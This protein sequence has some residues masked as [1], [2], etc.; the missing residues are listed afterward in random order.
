M[1]RALA[2]ALDAGAVR[3]QRL[4][5][6][7][8]AACLLARRG[9]RPCSRRSSSTRAC[10]RCA[11][12]S[13]SPTICLT[14]SQAIRIL[15]GETPQ[16][17]HTDD[18]FYRIARPRRGRQPELHL[19]ASTRSPRRTAPRRCVPGSHRW[20]DATVGAPARA[21]STSRRVPDRPPASHA[22]RRR[23]RRGSAATS[24]TSSCR[25]A[26]ASRSSGRSCIAGARTA[27]RGRACALSNQYCQPWARQQENYFLSVVARA[28]ARDVAAR[29]GAARIQRPPAVH[30]PRERPAPA[31]RPRR[32]HG[33]RPGQP[34]EVLRTN[35]NPR[36]E[37]YRT[38]RA[39]FLEQIAYLNEQLALA[40]AGGGEKYVERHI[41]AR[42][43]AG[44][45]AHRAAARSRLALPR[46]RAAR[47]PGAPSSR[48]AA[49]SISGIGVVSGVECVI[50]ANELDRA[51][52]AR[53]TRTA[54][55]RPARTMD[56][57]AQNRLP[58]INLTES[59]GA[60]LPNQSKIFVPGGRG[61]RE[62]TRRS[63]RAHPDDLS[64]VRQ[65]DRGRRLRARA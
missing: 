3:P 35:A 57:C 41:A 18:S 16:P 15:P 54:S 21:T 58:I 4:R 25:R 62:L 1:R 6:P 8:H 53:S 48:S 7:S 37:A 30:G 32:A 17:F 26:P 56:I 33:L 13:S 65:L 12:R 59:G 39:A 51:R 27:A 34:M 5:G 14:A 23:G 49:A 40:R 45:R 52:A 42:Q 64:R 20:E 46:A 63:R 2:P 50:T 60:D 24:S 29:A 47:R 22:R 61:F 31:P 55:R 38:N 43:A 28:G 19:R 10:S 36:S 11:T 44:A 9:A